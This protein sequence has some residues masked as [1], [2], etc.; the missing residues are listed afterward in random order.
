MYR[1]TFLIDRRGMHV[2]YYSL[3]LPLLC[4]VL[5]YGITHKHQAINVYLCYRKEL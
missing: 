5:K 1:A 3:F 2:L 4:T